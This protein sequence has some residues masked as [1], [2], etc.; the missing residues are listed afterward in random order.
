[1]IAHT[2]VS[3]NILHAFAVSPCVSPSPYLHFRLCLT[4]KRKAKKKKLMNDGESGPACA[5]TANSQVG[6]AA[7][8]TST[9]TTNWNALSASEAI[10]LGGALSFSNEKGTLPKVQQQANLLARPRGADPSEGQHACPYPRAFSASNVQSS[11]QPFASSRG[12]A[13]S[14]VGLEELTSRLYS[15]QSN[16]AQLSVNPFLQREAQ[17]NQTI[18]SIYNTSKEGFHP[19]SHERIHSDQGGLMPA[20]EFQPEGYAG[21]GGGRQVWLPYQQ[22][23]TSHL[24]GGEMGNSSVAPPS[25]QVNQHGDTT[26][27]STAHPASSSPR[28]HV[29]TSE[30]MLSSSTSGDD[31][32][33]GDHADELGSGVAAPLP[34]GAMSPLHF[35]ENETNSSTD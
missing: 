33:P 34:L 11:Q 28:A 13:H 27:P 12:A 22:Q 2:P 17:Q 21:V 9:V 32:S 1:M 8:S 23:G 24:H 7:T 31:W 25:R 18:A 35:G 5:P 30:V 6:R 29:G 20:P 15:S 3:L 26:L 14:M 4:M 10:S 19:I 16:N